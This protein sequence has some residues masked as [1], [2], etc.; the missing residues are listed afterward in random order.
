MVNEEVHIVAL[1]ARTP[2]G[3]TAESSAA[4][5]RGRIS[6]I[7]EHPFMVDIRGE[8]VRVARDEL[9]DPL[10]PTSGRQFELARS[11]LE[12]V[13]LKIQAP[14]GKLA[15][16]FPLLLGMTQDRYAWAD[17]QAKQ[18]IQQLAGEPSFGLDGWNI[19]PIREGHASALEAMRHAYHGITHGQYP[20]CVVGGV[21]SLVDAHTL[22][23]LDGQG[24]L[25]ADT[26]RSGFPPGEGAS[27][28]AL[29]SN[30]ARVYLGLPSLAIVRGAAS[31]IELKLRNAAEVCLGEGLTG[32]IA[33]AV[34]QLTPGRI[35]D[36]IFCD[37]NGERYRTEEWGFALLRNQE[38]F[39]TTSYTTAVA[40]WGDV[41]AASGAL[42]TTLAVQG[43]ARGYA[44]GT[45]SLIWASSD[46]GLRSAVVLERGQSS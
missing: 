32:A 40:E 38:H 6:R 17:S 2:V 14:K 19:Q 12:Q 33:N 43:W 34:A 39:R 3:L 16:Q 10:L 23:W 36:Q 28:I 22:V 18:L 5:V 8:L 42:L 26:V 31:N 21:D 44:Q 27:F 13:V 11:A 24:R 46:G 1:G 41:G 45:L 7:R 29:A 35:V 20:L 25:A 4:A 9:L 30:S 15:G 37:I